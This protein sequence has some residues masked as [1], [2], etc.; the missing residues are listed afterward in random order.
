M[1]KPVILIVDDLKGNRETWEGLFEENSDWPVKSFA[2]GDMAVEYAKKNRVDAAIVDYHLL[3][4]DINGNEVAEEI[5]RLWPKAYV[6]IVSAKV[7]DELMAQIQAKGIVDDV[8]ENKAKPSLVTKVRQHFQELEP[9]TNRQYN[10]KYSRLLSTCPSPGMQE[11]LGNVLMV[12]KTTA[13]VLI[14]GKTGVGKDIVAR[15][16]HEESDRNAAHFERVDCTRLNESIIEN[17]LFGHAKGAFTGAIETVPGAFVRADGGTV[18]I[19]E[20]GELPLEL[21]KKL[22]NTIE[23]KP[24]LPIGGQKHYKV[25]VRVIADTNRDLEAMV[26]EG[27]F[28]KDLYYRLKATMI[29]IPPLCERLED[30][31]VLTRHFVAEYAKKYHKSNCD[32]DKYAISVLSNGKYKWPGNVRELENTIENAVIRSRGNHIG[33]SSIPAEII[34]NQLQQQLTEERTVKT[35]CDELISLSLFAN[36]YY[37]RLDY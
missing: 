6:A 18:F 3:S 16:I 21:Q 15:S 25:D 5:K 11:V 9:V 32:I 37:E 1:K 35:I 7:K 13:T 22:L 31:E 19:N 23:G 8:W 20:V 36:G 33:L 24:V 2:R 34:N 26:K 28:R 10:G 30:I 12:A 4:N 17:E 27:K 14:R 29:T